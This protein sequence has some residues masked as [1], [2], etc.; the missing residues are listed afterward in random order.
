MPP[1]DNTHTTAATP[2][3]PFFNQK[4]LTPAAYAA[5][6]DAHGGNVNDV[7]TAITIPVIIRFQEKR[8]RPIPSETMMADFCNRVWT[9]ATDL[10]ILPPTEKGVEPPLPHPE[11]TV[12]E[13]IIQSLDGF[14]SGELRMDFALVA[15]QLLPL[16]VGVEP[17]TCC[18]AYCEKSPAGLQERQHKDHALGRISGAHCVDCPLF[19]LTQSEKHPRV[20]K[21]QWDSEKQEELE[22]SIDVFIPEEFRQLRL[23]L[24]LHRRRPKG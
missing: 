9:A 6:L 3:K 13:A 8:K 2:A 23:F 5:V 11:G 16:L 14:E 15:N 20:L 17:K 24:H 22:S 10:G 1:S 4:E 21:A 7:F 19:V 18:L 12:T